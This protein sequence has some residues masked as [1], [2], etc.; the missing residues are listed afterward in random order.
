MIFVISIVNPFSGTQEHSKILLSQNPPRYINIADN[1]QA[2][3]FSPFSQTLL[4][5]IDFLDKHGDC[6][7]TLLDA[8]TSSA[9]HE[10][11]KGIIPSFCPICITNIGKKH[12]KLVQILIFSCG[13][14]G[15]FC[16]ILKLLKSN[17]MNIN[18]FIYSIIPLGT[19]NDLSSACGWGRSFSFSQKNNKV[20]KCFRIYNKS[21]SEISDSFPPQVYKVEIVKTFQIEILKRI[22]GSIECN[23]DLWNAILLG[24]NL[25]NEPFFIEKMFAN[26]LSIGISISD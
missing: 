19:G 7:F 8:L 12:R 23:L 2:H 24:T 26:V 10:I 21:V 16:W 25:K 20:P 15:T 17:G 22:Y 9:R 1:I 4:P 11:L 6:I 18:N 13:G 5:F 14:D 3:I